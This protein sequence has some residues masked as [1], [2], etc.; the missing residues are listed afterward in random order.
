MPA[1]VLDKREKGT[2][3]DFADL[4]RVIHGAS[5]SSLE[6][7]N[8]NNPLIQSAM[9]SQKDD[10]RLISTITSIPLDFL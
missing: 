8:N 6:F 2:R 9:D 3:I 4:G 5:D 1:N 10:M 7:V